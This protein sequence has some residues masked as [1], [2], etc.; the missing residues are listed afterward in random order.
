MVVERSLT[1]DDLE[2]CQEL[3]VEAGWNQTEDDWRMILDIGIGRGL[4]EGASPVASAVVLPY[5]G[6]IGWVCMVLVAKDQ[7]RQGHA[8]RLLEW[9]LETCRQYGLTAGL[10]A[11]PDGRKV[12]EHLGFQDC[13]PIVRLQSSKSAINTQTGLTD[14]VIRSAM[15]SDL[16]E[17]IALDGNSFGADRSGLISALY[18]RE[19]DRAFVAQN[20]S[21]IDGFVLIRK[22]RLATQIGPLIATSQNTAQALLARVMKSIDGPV[23]L[24]LVEAHLDTR[25]LLEDSGFE[26]QRPFMRMLSGRGEAFGKPD[27]IFVLAGPELA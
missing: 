10:D 4:F 16:A 26:V 6:R 27:H 21:G 5:G 25:R 8:T 23:F 20:G 12:Y 3:S 22:G 17:I 18:Q 14:E 13:F 2:G 1:L 19:P 7:R 24:D 9:S 11:T 15:R